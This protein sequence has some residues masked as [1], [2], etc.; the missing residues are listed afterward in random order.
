MGSP[1]EI[2]DGS[3]DNFMN[4]YD[5]N[6][7][8]SAQPPPRKKTIYKPKAETIR[9]LKQMKNQQRMRDI[10]QQRQLQHQQQRQRSI[11]HPV[12]AGP[13]P[14]IIKSSLNPNAS[15][16]ELP[17]FSTTVH[18]RSAP[19]DPHSQLQN[20][21]VFAPHYYDNEC[22]D[23]YKT[24][25]THSSYSYDEAKVIDE[26]MQTRSSTWI[27]PSCSFLNAGIGIHCE[28]CSS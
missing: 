6:N 14:K 11:S 28:L 20:G 17:D 12:S 18:T 4:D 7:M 24:N 21:G 23:E 10:Q 3:A 1:P 26:P 9:R 27:C 19:F 22:V 8:L 2:T 16:F 5:I 25:D 13:P 15:A